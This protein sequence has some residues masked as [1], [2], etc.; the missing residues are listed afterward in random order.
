MEQY[1]NT[2]FEYIS[3][4]IT[5]PEADRASVRRSFKPVFFPKGTIVEK[6]GDVPGYHNFIAS[7]FMRNYHLDADNNEITTDLNDG[8]RFFTSY[9]HFV[10]R[11][12]SNENLHCIT[13]CTLLRISRDDADATAR[14][15]LT[16]K[17]YTIGI[18]QEHLQK[19]KDRINDMAN[20]TAE[21]R[22]AKFV[23]AN[24]NIVRNVP[25]KYIASYLGITQRHLSRLRGDS[26]AD[27]FT[28]Q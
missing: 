14:T 2:L 26:Q 6:A 23:Q 16:Q 1:Y 20:L 18:L 28:P 13:D 12:V 24:A 10:N 19:D 4:M 11:S 8:P 9:F 21:A 3:R 27:T 17:D 7:G 15:S 22:Y 25:L 5:L